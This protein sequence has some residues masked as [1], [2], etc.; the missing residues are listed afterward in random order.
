MSMM[1][2]ACIA[3]SFTLST[4]R[5]VW[6]KLLFRMRYSS[7]S[8]STTASSCSLMKRVIRWLSPPRERGLWKFSPG[9]WLS[10]TRRTSSKRG[11]SLNLEGWR[12][13]TMRPFRPSFRSMRNSRKLRSGLRSFTR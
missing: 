4:K 8:R 13:V 1:A 9:V 7:P 10:Q 2:F 6:T 11:S 3:N 5:R 12:R